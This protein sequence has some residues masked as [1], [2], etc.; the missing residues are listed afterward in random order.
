M[1]FDFTSMTAK[2]EAVTGKK[3]NYKG[4][5]LSFFEVRNL[6]TTVS[7]PAELKKDLAKLTLIRD[8]C[9]DNFGDNWIY[10]WV[11][12]CFKHEADATLFALKWK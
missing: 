8:W 12:F 11:D 6:T 2:Y 1:S 9:E 4:N 10:D 7:L 3:W 5:N